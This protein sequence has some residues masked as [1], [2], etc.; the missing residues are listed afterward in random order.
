MEKETQKGKRII[1]ARV[2]NRD[3]RKLTRIPGLMSEITRLEQQRAWQYDRMFSITQH[4]TGMPGGGNGD[5]G[6]DAAFAAISETDQKHG[7]QVT[8]YAREMNEAENILNSIEDTTVRAFAA[9]MH[10]CGRS[11]NQTMRELCL[12]EWEFRRIKR[13]IENAPDMAHVSIRAQDMASERE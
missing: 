11:R 3:V 10:L 7:E 13:A 8:E 4:L 5:K 2:R 12:T 1:P 9:L 6:Y